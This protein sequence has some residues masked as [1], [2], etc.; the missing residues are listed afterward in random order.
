MPNV[1]LDF[2]DLH[3]GDIVNGQYSADGVTISSINHDGSVDAHNPPMV[4]DTSNPTGGDSDLATHNMGNVLIFS[5]DGDSNDPDDNASGGI[6]SFDFAEPTEVLNFRVLDIEEGGSVRLYNEEGHLIKTVHIPVTGNNGQATVHINTDDV[7]R[8][9]VQLNGSGAIDGVCFCTTDPEDDLDGV[10]SGDNGAD[11]IDAGYEGDPDGDMID[12]GDAILPGEAADDDIVDALGG[13]DVITSGAGD[14][15]VFAGSGNDTVDGGAGDDIIFGDSNYDGSQGGGSTV[16]E[17]LNWSDNQ[18]NI[19]GFTQ[20]TG[21]VNVTFSVL[22]EEGSADTSFESDTQYVAGIDSGSETI[23]DNSSLYSVTNGQGNDTAYRLQ[24]SAPVEDVSFRINDIDG[25][26]RV[27]V[28]AYDANGNAIT[29]NLT[30]PG[31]AL[32]LSNTDGVSG[33]DTADSNGGY[34]PDTAPNYSVEVNIPGPVARIEILHVQNG[35][36]NSGINVTDV[37]Y[38]VPVVDTGADGN[39][40]LRGGDGNDT[41]FGEGGNDRLEGQAGDDTLNG[42]AGRDVILGGAGDDTAD[43]GDGND[44]IW[45]GTGNDFAEGGAGNDWMHGQGGDDTLSGGDGDDMLFG[46]AGN[47]TLIGGDGADAIKG[48]DGRDT[49]LGG[50]DGD[51]VDGGSGGD[52]YDVLDLSGEGPFRIVNETVDADGNS[53]S[54]TVEFLDSDGNVTGSLEFTEIEEIIGDRVNQGPTANNDTA[55]VDEDDSVVIDVLGNDT[56]PEGDDLTIVEAS[57][58][59]G[60]VTVNPDGTITFTPAENFNGDTTITYEIEDEAGNTSTA[61]VAVTVNPINDAPDAVNDTAETDEE[62]PVTINVLDNDTDVDGDTLEITA[63][64]V[65]ADQGTV[66]IVGGQ[67]VFTPAENFTGEAT[68]SYSITDGNG[69]TDVAEVA[70][71]VNNVNDGPVAVDDIAETDEDTPVTID[72]LDNDEDVDGDDLT[73]TGATVPADQGTVEIVG[74]ELV[75]TPAENFNGPATITYTVSDGNG[76]TDEGQALVNVGAVNDGPTAV[77]DVAETDED[78]PVTIDVVGNDEDPDGDDLTITAASVPA[79]QG[80]VEIVGN[81]LVFTPAENFNGDVTISYS[82]TD[83][84]GGTSSAEVA[85]TVN[86][87]ND[88]PVAVDDIETTDEDVAVV[89]DLLGNDTDVDG[90]D[91]TIASVSVDPAEGTVVDNGDGTVTFTPAPNF[92]GPVTITY[93]V[94]DGNGGTDDGEAVVNV[95]AVNDAPIA[96]DD[97]AETDEDTPVTI[98]VLDNDSDPDGDDISIIS[99]TVPADQGTVEIVDNELLFTPAPDFEGDATITYTISDGMGLTDTGEVAVTVNPVDDAPVTVDDLAETDEDTP[100]TI[101]PLAND[102]DPDGD[103]LSIAGIPVAENG[104]VTV[105]PDGTIEYTPDPDFNGTDTITYVATDPDGNET[106]GTIIVTVAPINDD[107]VAVD[108][109]ATTDEDTAVTI[110]LIGNDTDVD[111]DPL[112]LGSVS[113]PADQ[114][115]VVDNGDGTVTFTPAPDFNGEATITYTVEDG[116]GGSDEGQAIV[117]VD[118]VNDGP[119]AVDDSDTTDEDTPITVD[120][121]AN[122]SDPEGD[123]LTVTNATVPAD[124]GT[125]VDNGDGTV[126][127][128]PADNFNGEATISY[129]ISDGNGGTDTAEHTITVTPVNDDPVANDD[130][131]VVDEDDS[132]VISPLGNDTDVDGD[133]ITIESFTQPEN[134]TLTD[135]GDG[136]F[137]YEPDDGYNGPDSFTYTVSDGNG[138]TDTATV[139]ITVTP[140][141]DD[142]VAEDDSENTTILSPVVISVLANDSDPDGDDLSVDSFTQPAAGGT[143]TDNG[144]GTL[145]FTPDGTV[146]GEVTFEYTVTDGNGS[147]DTATVTVLIRDGIVEGTA[148]D[149]LIEAGTYLDDPEGDVVDG[150]DEFLPGEGPEDDI[151]LAGDGN[152]TVNAG[153]GDDEVYGED[154]D[155]VLNGGAG[156]DYL[157]GGEG[158]DIISGGDGNDTLDAGQGAD[159][160]FGEDGDD[161]LLGGPGTDLLDGGTGNDTILGGNNDDT[162]IGGQGDDVIEG[163]DG[164]DDIRGNQ[165]ED[166]IDGGLG[167]DTINAGNDN[168]TVDGGEGNDTIQ[169]GD[170]DDTLIGGLG[171]DDIQGNDGDDIIEG[172]EGDDVLWGGAGNDTIDGGDGND[173][174]MGGSGDDVVDLGDGD[175]IAQTGSGDDTVIGGLGNDTIETNDGNDTVEGGDGNDVINTSGHAPLPDLGYPGLFPSDPNPNDDIDFVDGGAGDDTITTGDDADTI[176]GGTGNDTIDG[177]LDADTIDGG[178]GNDRIVGGEG[179]DVIDGGAGDDTI[180]AGIDPDL[181]LPDNLDIPDDTDLVPNNGMDIVNGGDGNDTIFGADDDDVLN[182]DAGDDFIDGGIDDDTITGGTGNDTIIG[183]EGSDTLSGGDDEDTFLV[184]AGEGIGDVV[185]GGDGGVDNDT[186]DLTGSGPLRIVGETVDAD[187]NSTSGTVEFLDGVGGDVIGTLEFSEIENIVPCFTPGTSIAT[188]RG[189][190]LVEDLQVGDKIITRDNGI[191][192]IR[193]IGAKRMDGREL[194]TNPH[195]QPVLIQKGSL[196]NGLPERDMLVSPNHRML[197]NNDRVSLYFE[198]NEVLVSAKHLVNPSEGV[199]TINSMGTTYI[200]FMFDNHEVVLSNGAWTESFQPGDY[201]LKGI[202]NAQRNEIFELFPE[203]QGEAGREAYASARLTLKKHEARMLFK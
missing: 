169:G 152:D 39:D 67:L 127:F 126:T 151:I 78:T 106:P 19:T 198:E 121:L 112:T 54:G 3:R 176:L 86:P 13:D 77:D 134:G 88:D 52:D 75:F 133:T 20:D 172:N 108:D 27:T 71:T 35:P 63:A 89:V 175:D 36:N 200:H 113:V 149:D 45:M 164:N 118:S 8:M 188:P 72:V 70:V 101:D 150:G 199:Q 11:V 170:G 193:W 16:R 102:S 171:N 115:T 21:N 157:S 83:G 28:R 109:A 53:T 195:L 40:T 177:G 51:T 99:A 98:D 7:A 130:D 197:V 37:F 187:G 82:I 158:D 114:G 148:G 142:V 1:L 184:G 163:N 29:V 43:G 125:L 96:V 110:D 4:F 22:T 80:T 73:I 44:E 159:Q 50:N 186:L 30:N 166:T 189:E 61:T 137:T 100:V 74:N 87:V 94:S 69:G 5:E 116:Q 201:S 104:T 91:L 18:G 31:S 144:D 165:G 34:A 139:N 32:T 178:D 64:S 38:D 140:V 136:T 92:N 85:V 174:V 33:A 14:D 48:G 190:M 58:P 49:I 41:I 183:G 24:Y 25:D 180:Y 123:A 107:P 124:Q 12:A 81:E 59:D 68:I 23:N 105:N 56:D 46:E 66:E 146:D 47:D 143:V 173:N 168:D 131:V 17:S 62:T 203:L 155:D 147:F 103:E 162:I 15:E 132:V 185:D 202:G 182:G 119:D 79:D 57:S 60:D 128:T 55:E 138:G 9:E 167:D 161:L 145:T 153:L 194:Q 97:T 111:G 156:D 129:E 120:L 84:N 141:N 42:G 191:Q 181:G 122:D 179:S 76:G 93:T 2:E 26:G 117:T 192:E 10:V 6:F 95:G 160:L 135:N 90:D 154:G 196:G 65:P